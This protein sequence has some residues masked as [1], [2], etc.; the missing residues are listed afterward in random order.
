M[1]GQGFLYNETGNCTLT[2]SSFDQDY[3]GT[4][5]GKPP[6]ALTDADREALEA[7]LMPSPDGTRWLF[8]N[9]ARCLR[10]GSPISGSATETPY[11]L[12]YP[13]TVDRDV[14]SSLRVGLKDVLKRA[15]SAVPWK[16]RDV[17]LG[18]LMA[19]ILTVVVWGIAYL[20]GRLVTE[21]NLDIWV[22]VFSVL[23]ELLLLVPVWWFVRHKYGLSIKSLGFTKFQFVWLVAGFGLLIACYFFNGMYAYLIS[24]FGR[25]MREGM[26]P[27]IDELATPWPLVFSVV[28][29]APLAEETFFRGFV[30]NGLRARMDWWWAAV[31][32][33]ALFAFAHLELWFL[34]PAFVLGF[35]FAFLY[36]KTNSIWPG[37]I[38][39]FLVNTI[40][41]T[42]TL[43]LT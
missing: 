39:H 35:L 40:A 25:E 5:G 19:V 32:S 41:M 10:C 15:R 37:M 21:P 8:S 24:L 11:Y 2:W 9:P 22:D 33:A 12:R 42:L 31:I 16:M 4:V 13:C 28:I 20:V 14:R 43:T 3:A 7:R 6:W 38:L 26:G 23:A 34:V 27:T 1:G 17:W 29:L 18:V 36:Q 30:F